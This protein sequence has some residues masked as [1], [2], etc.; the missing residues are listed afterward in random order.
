MAKADVVKMEMPSISLKS[1][2]PIVSREAEEKL[3][4][5]EDP[6]KMGRE[7]LLAEP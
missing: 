1:V 6:T 4:L 3:Q 7:G 2:A 5:V